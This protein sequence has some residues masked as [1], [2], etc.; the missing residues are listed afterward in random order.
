M[1]APKFQSWLTD[2]QRFSMALGY[3]LDRMA[4][5]ALTDIRAMFDEARELFKDEVKPEHVISS[6]RDQLFT[7]LLGNDTARYFGYPNDRLAQQSKKSYFSQNLM[8]NF[9]L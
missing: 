7:L 8:G 2:E 1:Y 4:D 6:Y 5:D 9:W 3:K